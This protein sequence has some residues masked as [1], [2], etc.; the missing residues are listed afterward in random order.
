MPCPPCKVIINTGLM[1]IIAA[2]LA[3]ML[4]LDTNA[5]KA[6][7][8]LAEAATMA[9]DAYSHAI[10]TGALDMGAEH[11]KEAWTGCKHATL[12]MQ[13]MTEP[14]SDESVIAKVMDDWRGEV[15]TDLKAFVA[16]EWTHLHEAAKDAQ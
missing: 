13:W 2:Y 8:A 15:L 4:G 5:G 6:A 7:T 16:G 14:Y 3:K 12:L 9:S 11:R 1:A 10:Y